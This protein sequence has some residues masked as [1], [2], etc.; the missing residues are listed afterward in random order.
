MSRNG[1]QLEDFGALFEK[2]RRTAGKGRRVLL[3]LGTDAKLEALLKSVAEAVRPKD[4]EDVLEEPT[5]LP[6]TEQPF[7]DGKR[8]IAKA[9]EELMQAASR[10]KEDVATG[11]SSQRLK[12][13]LV[14]TTQSLH[15]KERALAD[16]RKRASDLKNEAVLEKSSADQARKAFATVEEKRSIRAVCL[17]YTS[18]AADE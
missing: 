14:A 15:S 3:L 8:A 7:E 11:T 16:A 6:T 4:D 9:R 12:E 13:T 18:D 17:L 1:H 2:M 10:A 5:D